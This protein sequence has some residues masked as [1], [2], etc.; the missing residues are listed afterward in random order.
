MCLTVRVSILRIALTPAVCRLL[1]LKEL[2]GIVNSIA[3]RELKRR[4]LA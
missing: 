3:A 1:G 4:G 2:T